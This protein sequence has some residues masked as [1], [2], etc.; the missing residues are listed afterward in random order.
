MSTEAYLDAAGAPSPAP[1]EFSIHCHETTVHMPQPRAAVR[2]A[3]PIVFEGMIAPMAIFYTMLVIAG[4]RGAILAALAWSYAAVIRR[5]V[6]GERISTLL[7]LGSVLVTLR[8]IV[9][10]VTGSSF[11]YF[12]QP[13]AGTVVIA[14]VLLASAVIRRPFTQR[15]AHDFCPL[16]SELLAQPRV[17]Q[18]FVRI[19]LV[20]AAV[21]LVNS[22][23]V[24]W[25]LMSSSL[26][27]FVLERTAVTWSLTAGAIFCS[28][29]GFTMTM[30]RSGHT[31]QWGRRKAAVVGAAV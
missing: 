8:T 19:S 26:K 18:F 9:A 16:D 2:H 13:L 12:V 28:I 29:Y 3:V 15:F 17:Q 23:T 21:L 22:G 5:V 20:W 6:R 1:P 4:F 11:V 14:V 30:R 7:I 27:A 31:I 10:F 25:L 24:L